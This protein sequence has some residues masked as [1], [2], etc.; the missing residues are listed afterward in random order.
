MEFLCYRVLAAV[1]DALRG[2]DAVFES[3]PVAIVGWLAQAAPFMDTNFRVLVGVACELCEFMRI[4]ATETATLL[5][6]CVL[7]ADSCRAPD[8]C[9]ST[10]VDRVTGADLI[11][12]G[13]ESRENRRVSGERA[14]ASL[15]KSNVIADALDLA[16]W[17]IEVKDTLS[18]LAAHS[19]TTEDW[20]APASDVEIEPRLRALELY[21][22]YERT[23]F[24]GNKYFSSS[25]PCTRQKGTASGWR[26]SRP[27]CCAAG[28]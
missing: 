9:A 17:N 2:A 22:A 24:P 12:L 23:R 5:T 28:S 13:A 6:G 25:S 26:A 3:V 10:D 4:Q 1:N 11:S 15:N 8:Q 18:L 20:N 21:D 16:Y 19:G 7:C 27:P 14:L